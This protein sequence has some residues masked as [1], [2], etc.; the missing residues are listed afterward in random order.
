MSELDTWLERIGNW[1]KDRK[2]DQVEK[3]EP[4]IL[5]PPD[6]LWGPLITDEQS[7]GIA[8]WLDGCLR[9]FTFYRYKDEI[10]TA[11]TK[12]P[13]P[14]PPSI[15]NELCGSHHQEKAFQY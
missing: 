1:Y 8:C 7:K 13:P 3:L 2:H 14:S 9:I 10:L 6:A 12:L 15:S 5:T 11:S 4:L